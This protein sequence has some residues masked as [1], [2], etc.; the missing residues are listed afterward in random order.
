MRPGVET[1]GAA[2]LPLGAAS[3]R[4]SRALAG[5]GAMALAVA[6]DASRGIGAVRRHMVLMEAVE[7]P[8]H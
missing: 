2:P 7:A 3:V 8:P 6:P 5:T 1:S 4:G